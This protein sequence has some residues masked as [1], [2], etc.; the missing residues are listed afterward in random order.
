MEFKL[1]GSA[2][3]AMMQIEDRQYDLPFAEDSRKVYRIEVNFNG[4][5]RNI[6]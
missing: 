6:E 3:E 2:E 1:D 5:T 4:E